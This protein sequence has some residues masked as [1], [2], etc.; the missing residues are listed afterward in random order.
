MQFGPQVHD[1]QVQFGLEHPDDGL[2]QVQS[3][4]QVQDSQVQFGLS[5]PAD[6][7]F[8]VSVMTGL[9]Q[10]PSLGKRVL[11]RHSTTDSVI[12]TTSRLTPNDG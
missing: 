8:A 4:P 5:Q 10:S 9:S 3:G 6:C 7:S 1:S 12:N 2:P 11:R